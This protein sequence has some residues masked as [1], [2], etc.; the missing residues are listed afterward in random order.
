[1]EGYEYERNEVDEMQSSTTY[2][3]NVNPEDSG[4]SPEIPGSPG[5]GFSEFSSFTAETLNHNAAQINH[6]N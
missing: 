5:F 2:G 4:K 1:M 6:G 3:F